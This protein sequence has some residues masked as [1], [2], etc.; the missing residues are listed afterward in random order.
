MNEKGEEAAGSSK[1][2]TDSRSAVTTARGDQVLL[3]AGQ[4]EV[5]R[6]GGRRPRLPPPP[7]GQHAGT[8][9]TPVPTLRCRQ[10]PEGHGALAREERE[11]QQNGPARGSPSDRARGTQKFLLQPPKELLGLPAVTS[12]P[13]PDSTVQTSLQGRQE[14][15]EPHPGQTTGPP[16]RLPPAEPRPGRAGE[17]PA[18]QP[19]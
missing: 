13:H 9:T 10:C 3:T 7:R 5:P 12:Q 14:S 15:R 18:L 6:T 4:A 16:V 19:P 1:Q 8:A 2:G 11:S 17:T